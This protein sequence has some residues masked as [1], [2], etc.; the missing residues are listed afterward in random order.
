M[1]PVAL[2]LISF[3]NQGEGFRHMEEDLVALGT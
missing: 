2:E 3:I 1:A